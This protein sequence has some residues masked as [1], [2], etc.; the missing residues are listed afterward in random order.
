MK[1]SVQGAFEVFNDY[2]TSFRWMYVMDG[3][4]II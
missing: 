1:A 2:D 4:K 3:I